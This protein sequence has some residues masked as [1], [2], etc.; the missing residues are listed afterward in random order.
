MPHVPL[1]AADECPRVKIKLGG[2]EKTFV[3]E[4]QRK[5]FGRPFSLSH[6]AKLEFGAL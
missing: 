1:A 3:Y 2:L 6:E 4:I 5:R